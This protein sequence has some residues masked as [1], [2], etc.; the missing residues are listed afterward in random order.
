MEAFPYREPIAP[1]DVGD[2]ESGSERLLDE[3]I[4]ACESASNFPQRVEAA[5]RATLE[6]F[7]AEPDLGLLLTISPPAEDEL[8]VRR[9]ERWQQRFGDLLRGAAERSPSAGTHPPFVEPIL[10]AG[11]RW[12]IASRLITDGAEDLEDLLPDLME[13]LLACYFGPYDIAPAL[14]Q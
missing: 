10:I 11:L 13:F 9:H 6:L 4:V 1:A 2:Y 5:L 3:I 7:A 12:Q 8:A 14:T